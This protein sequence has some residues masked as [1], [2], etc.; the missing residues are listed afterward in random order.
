MNFDFLRL[1]PALPLSTEAAILLST[2]IVSIA[3]SIATLIFNRPVLTSP[4]NEDANLSVIF[5]NPQGLIPHLLELRTRLLNSLIAILI[6]TLIATALTEQVL[7]LLAEPIGGM[8]ALQAIRVTE[9]ISVFFRVA[10][11]LGLILASPYVIAQIW[12]FIA[13]GLKPAE[14]SIFYL[15]FPFAFIL[16]L[17]GVV[18]AYYVMLPVAVPFLTTFMGI[19]ALPTLEDYITFVTTVLL[20]VG[21]SFEM[22]MIIYLLA[23][24]K[25]VNARMLAQNWRIAV[26]AIAVLAAII[27]PT[28]D[29]INMGIVAAPLLVL[30]LLSIILAMFA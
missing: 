2:L 22:P 26:V 8:D 23:R 27:T 9:S 3:I 18:F 17:A 10:V 20:W 1:L 30:Y 16:F 28:P 4:V 25:L 12:I 6:G 21:V 14:R 13:A 29:P 5:E 7:T 24:A 19:H 15:L 11:T